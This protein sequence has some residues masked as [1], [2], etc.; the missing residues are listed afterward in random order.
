MLL[1]GVET[2]LGDAASDAELFVSDEYVTVPLAGLPGG[3]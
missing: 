3:C 2:V 1:P